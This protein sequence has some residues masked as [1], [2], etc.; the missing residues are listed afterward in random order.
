MASN[1]DETRAIGGADAPVSY[2]LASVARAIRRELAAVRR[3]EIP[4]PQISP[5]LALR[6]EPGLSNA[7]LARRCYVTPQSMNEVVFALEREGW[8]RRVPDDS[9]KRILR[10]ALTPEGRTLLRGWEKAIRALEEHLFEGL[11][12]SDLEHL[13]TVLHRCLDNMAAGMGEPA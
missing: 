7:E 11:T 6:D 13:T 8:I 3:P 4:G 12:P 2:L 5:L 10:A 1:H 9:N